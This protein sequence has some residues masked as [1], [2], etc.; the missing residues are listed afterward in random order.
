METLFGKQGSY[1]VDFFHLCESLGAAATACVANDAG[2]WMETQKGR[3][4]ANQVYA[5]LEAL[6][7]CLETGYEG[8]APCPTAAVICAT[9]CPSCIRRAHWKMGCRLSREKS[10]AHIAM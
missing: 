2:Y 4:K 3:L 8:S 5:V 9:A 1:L 7:P 6:A 10:K